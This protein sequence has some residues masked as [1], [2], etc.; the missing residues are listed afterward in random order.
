MADKKLTIRVHGLT[1]QRLV[2]ARV[3]AAKLSS[4][5]QA[6]SK[7]DK[8]RNG[9]KCLQFVISDLKIS[10]AVA[11]IAE[12][13]ASAKYFAQYSS[14]SAVYETLEAVYNGQTSSL[15]HEPTLLSALKRLSSGANKDY[16]HL[17]IYVDQDESTAVRV[18]DFFEKQISLVEAAR[19]DLLATAKQRRF[20]GT[21]H[22][23]FDGIL[24]E[25]DLRGAVRRAKLILTAGGA[26]IDCVC[27]SVE[28]PE[29]R[30]SLDKRARVSGIAHYDV[31]SALP[32]RVDIKNIKLV[33]DAA[34]LIKWRGAFKIHNDTEEW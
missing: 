5:V 11:E 27:N 28:V 13:P 30:E 3:F 18:D 31:S 14:V 29:L 21:A 1:H 34:D 19:E 12:K 7:T 17:E 22:A 10:S 33:K 8:R 16:S 6:L 32:I 20:V 23:S 25:V 9:H 2:D 4:L 15:L 26:E 24:K